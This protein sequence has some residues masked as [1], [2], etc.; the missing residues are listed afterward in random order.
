MP[1]AP[2]Q[3][4][5]YPVQVLT[6][7][8][9]IQGILEPIGPIVNYLNDVNRQYVPFLDAT[10][11]SLTPGP[12]GK[13]TRPQLI[14]PKTDLVAMYL[15]DA[16]ARASVQHMKRIERYIA[17]LPSLVCRGEFHLGTDTRWQDVLSLLVA[18]FFGVTAV[19]AFPLVTLPGP[20][21]QQADLLILNRAHVRMLHLDQA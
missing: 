7:G 2:A 3:L 10:V 17:Y 1:I 15:D 6:L 5:R 21:P 4:P 14:I 19:T 16:T 11:N 8:Y 12:L 9:H 20:F 18:D 13:V